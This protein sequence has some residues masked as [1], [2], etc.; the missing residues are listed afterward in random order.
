MDIADLRAAQ[1]G[2]VAVLMQPAQQQP[3]EDHGVGGSISWLVCPA[4][5]RGSF[6]GRRRLNAISRSRALLLCVIPLP[7]FPLPAGGRVSHYLV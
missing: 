3:A 5:S 1:I 7:R 4:S 2:R 6:L